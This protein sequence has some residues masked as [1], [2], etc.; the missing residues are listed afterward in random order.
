MARPARIEENRPLAALREAAEIIRLLLAGDESGFAGERF[1]LAPGTALAYSRVRDAIPLLVGTWG[2]DTMRW[3]ATVAAEVKLGGTA[4]PDFVRVARE[5]IAND[6]VGVVTGCVTVVDE[7][8]SRARALAAEVVRG[9]LDVV[10]HL[11]P[12]LGLEPGRPAPLEKFCIAGTPE[13]VAARVSELWD[14]GVDRVELG[15]PQG[16]TTV[17]GVELIC[18]RVLPLLR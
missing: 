14:A 3:A 17:E 10:A 5:W 18:E 9:Y 12:T 1:T 7:D 4:N 8:G 6:E 13:Q 2:R 15:T 16:R 11:D